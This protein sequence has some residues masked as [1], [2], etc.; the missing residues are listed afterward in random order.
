MMMLMMRMIIRRIYSYTA[1]GAAPDAGALQNILFERGRIN[2]STTAPNLFI[3]V[4]NRYP[5]WCFWVGRGRR[6]FSPALAITLGSQFLH[7]GLCWIVLA[8]PSHGIPCVPVGSSGFSYVLASVLTLIRN[9][10]LNG[11]N[12]VY[13][14]WRTR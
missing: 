13:I 2:K 5:S 8:G 4:R 6:I 3:G 10:N 14:T 7:L 12:C 9:H 1:A 11:S